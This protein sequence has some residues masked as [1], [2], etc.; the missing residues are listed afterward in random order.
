MII[1]LDTNIF[2]KNWYFDNP[3]F[4]YLFNFK[5]FSKVYRQFLIC[6]NL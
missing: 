2:Y 5:L 6:A 1:Y 4:K 3:H